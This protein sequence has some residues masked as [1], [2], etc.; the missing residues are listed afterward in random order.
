[1]AHNQSPYSIIK[2]PI[3]TEKLNAFAGLNKYIFWV[4]KDANKIDIK[5]A[6][7]TIYKVKVSK[8]N[9]MVIKGKFKRIRWGQEGKTSSWKKAV[10]TL[11]QGHEI[12]IT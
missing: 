12:K 10:V 11:H 2:S 9:A 5:R 4:A 6:I 7:E 1:M 3:I 8:V